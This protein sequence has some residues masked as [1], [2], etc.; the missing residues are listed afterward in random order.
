[1]K[2][3]L[4]SALLALILSLSLTALPAAA[5]EVDQ[6]K[7]LLQE[8]YV[9]GV[10]ESVLALDS[11]EEILQA[12]GDPYTT[13]F[14]AEEYAAF[15]Q[16]V[17]GSSVTGIGVSVQNI[18]QD[19]GFQILSILPDSPALEAGLEAGARIIAVDGTPLTETSNIQTLI[20]GEEG[21][22]V[23]VTVIRQADG[24]EKDYTMERRAVDIPIV[25]YEEMGDAGYIDCTSFGDSTADTVM[26]ALEELDEDVSVWI[27]DLR[28]NPGGTAQAA[29]GTAGAF[30]GGATMVY[31][32]DAGGNYSYIYTLPTMEDMT[33]KP[34]IVLTSAYSASGSELF[35]A[36]ARDYDFGISL[37]QRTFGKGIAQIILD[38]TNTSGLFDGDALRVTTY[39]FFS[40]NGTTN[41]IVGILPTLLIS[42][43]NTL[44]AAALLSSPKP[45]RATGHLKLELA[46]QTFYL[47]LEQSGEH[48]QAFTELLEALPPSALLYEGSGTTIWTQ[49]TPQ[50]VAVKIRR[51]SFNPRTVSD[52]SSSPFREEIE[53]LAAYQLVEGYEDG[54]FRPD[55]TITRAEFCAMVAAALNLPANHSALTFSD[56]STDAW[57]ADAVSAMAS[58]GFISGYGDGTFR[59]DGTITYEEMVTIL[60]AV[61]AWCNMEGAA[62]NSQSVPA[63]EWA[64]YNTYSSWAQTPARTLNTLGALVGDLAPADPCTRQAAAGTLCTLM[65]KIGLI[66]D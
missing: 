31:F 64:D 42:Q 27:M 55:G 59:P 34:L 29:A 66:W 39:R 58:L 57:Y 11:L 8:Y 35:A 33:D 54:T 44:E 23:T 61:A 62:L 65:E 48:P 14:T 20:G 52:L 26:A 21:T 1:M 16:Q 28:S 6:A 30:V 19:G 10:P 38:D 24:Q 60:A 56:T 17:N 36:A 45:Q 4:L 2:K 15:L 47:D 53:T 12:L 9:D 43:E 5:L 25:T 22:S 32:L 49:T 41:H 46:G 63:G 13:Y 18:F 40:P 37:G 50:Q 7:E 51:A 3:R